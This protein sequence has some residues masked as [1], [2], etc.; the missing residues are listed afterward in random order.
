MLETLRYTICLIRLQ[1]GYLNHQ[2]IPQLIHAYMCNIVSILQVPHIYRISIQLFQFIQNSMQNILQRI[3]QIS[4]TRPYI[5]CMKRYASHSTYSSYRSYR[6]ARY[7]HPIIRTPSYVLKKCI[8][9]YTYNH[10][11]PIPHIK[12]YI[13]TYTS[14]HTYPILCMRTLYTHANANA[15]M[16]THAMLR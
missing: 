6:S 5:K 10:T 14:N 8:P 4:S 15:K 1:V 9:I 16:I 11:R 2:P 7:I 12:T 3:Y 13:P